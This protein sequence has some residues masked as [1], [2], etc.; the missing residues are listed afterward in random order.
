MTNG[1]TQIRCTQ[2]RKTRRKDEEKHAEFEEKSR[3]IYDVNKEKI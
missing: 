2:E 3:K 1:R